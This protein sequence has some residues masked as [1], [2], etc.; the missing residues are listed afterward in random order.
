MKGRMYVSSAHDTS[1]T[2]ILLRHTIALEQEIPVE[3]RLGQVEHEAPKRVD[4]A[5]V[6]LIRTRRILPNA[7]GSKWRVTGTR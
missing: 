7:A 1:L 4:D 3:M 2:P 6:N 5:T